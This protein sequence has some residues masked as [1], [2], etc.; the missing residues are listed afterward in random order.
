VQRSCDSS[1]LLLLS[2]ARSTLLLKHN[3]HLLL[4]TLEEL[5]EHLHSSD[6]RVNRLLLLLIWLIVR[7]LH[8]RNLEGWL[9]ASL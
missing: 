1:D 4:L 8:A 5:V 9:D 6:T 2:L 7:R 3:G